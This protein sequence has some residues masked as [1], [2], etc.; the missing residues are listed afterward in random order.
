MLILELAKF[1]GEVLLRLSVYKILHVLLLRSGVLLI[2]N[3][4][5]IRRS[6]VSLLVLIPGSS[7]VSDLL[8][9]LLHLTLQ[10][11][12]SLLRRRLII[13]FRFLHLIIFRFTFLNL[14]SLRH[15]HCCISRLLR[16]L[17][18]WHLRLCNLLV[19]WFRLHLVL[20]A[21]LILHRRRLRSTA[22]LN[23]MTI[24]SK[25]GRRILRSIARS[26]NFGVRL[27]LP[28]VRIY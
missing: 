6:L 17:I 1:F 16:R 8:L 18:F 21:A 22:L 23:R 19:G 15:L 3:Q 2:G 10:L 11:I 9:Q 24:M 20:G 4:I 14:M 12:I 25:R 28:G 5:G 27:L 26:L 7:L 13:I